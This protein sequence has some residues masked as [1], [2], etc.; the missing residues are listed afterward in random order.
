M[1]SVSVS[2]VYEIER[3]LEVACCF[4]IHTLIGA[5]EKKKTKSAIDQLR[6]H[7]DRA[8]PTIREALQMSPWEIQPAATMLF[9]I[10]LF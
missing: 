9:L 5:G 2:V 1:P 7:R 4:Q 10:L 8:T 6:H 3:W